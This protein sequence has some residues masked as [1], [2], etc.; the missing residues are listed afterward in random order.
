MFRRMFITHV[1]CSSNVSLSFYS[2]KHDY[3]SRTGPTLNISFSE[4]AVVLSVFQFQTQVKTLAMAV[5]AKKSSQISNV[6]T[7][8]HS[9]K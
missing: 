3:P 4:V 6:N 7:K 1:K 8:M 9:V 2:S 5:A